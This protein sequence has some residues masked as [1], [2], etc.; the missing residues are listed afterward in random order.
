PL[1]V[2]GSSAALSGQVAQRGNF[3]GNYVVFNSITNDS[4]LL[5]KN[6]F[7]TR[8]PINA[9]QIIPRVTPLTAQIDPLPATPRVF[10]NGTARLRGQ[11]AGVLPFS[12][13]WQK[14]GADLTDGGNISG[15]TTATLVIANVTAGDL[16]SYSLVV[17]NPGGVVTSTV[18]AL[19]LTAPV[20]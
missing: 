13:R 7:N 10:P 16:A 19:S 3:Q 18:A 9:V 11:V 12:Y 4:F 20:A 8:I 2:Y 15:S 1:T 6:Q 14:N 5:R 17:T